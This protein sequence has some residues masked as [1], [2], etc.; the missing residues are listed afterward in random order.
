M[1]RKIGA[2]KYFECS[3]VTREGTK[4]AFDTMLGMVVE[5]SPGLRDRFLNGDGKPLRGKR[6]RFGR[7]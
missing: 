7:F 5:A 2:V 6:W 1:A 4:E 3:A